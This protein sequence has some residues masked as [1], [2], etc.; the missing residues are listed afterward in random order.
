MLAVFLFKGDAEHWWKTTKKVLVARHLEIAW[1][2][3]VTAFHH[4]FIPH[5][6]QKK[7]QADFMAFIQGSLTVDQYEA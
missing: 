3:F 5:T 2:T 1:S 4:Q 6:A 7:I